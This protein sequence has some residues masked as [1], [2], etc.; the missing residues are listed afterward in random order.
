VRM[1][2][3]DV[4]KGV[5]AEA[6][7]ARAIAI[8]LPVPQGTPEANHLL[9]LLCAPGFST[10]DESDRASG[11]GVGMGVVQSAVEELSGSMRLE[12]ERGTGTRFVIELPVTLAIT[13]ALIAKVGS[14]TFAVPQGSVREVVEVPI[15]TLLQVERNEV[16][17]YRGAA[18]PVVRL[19]RLFGLPDTTCDRLHL[20]VVGVGAAALGIAVDRITGQR[21]IV[22]RAIADSLARVEGISGAT[23][24]G[25]GHV[26]LIL[27]PAT[28]ARHVRERPD[29]TFAARK[30][31]A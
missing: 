23:D 8:G 12:T 15:A 19:S 4:G 31:N 11:R 16:M 29:R 27:D 9:S 10:R 3:S 26:V 30:A 20:F 1:D 22:V 17:P 2:I 25:D 14:E 18:L 13:D 24:L 6:V 5:D 28:L 21:E 7:I